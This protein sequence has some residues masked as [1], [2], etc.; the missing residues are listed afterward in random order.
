MSFGRISV[1]KKY[2]ILSAMI[3]LLIF[4]FY[5]MFTLKTQLSPETNAPT[6]TVIT[7]YP[8]ALALDVTTDVSKPLED[9]FGKLNGISDISST[10]QDNMS[11]IKLTFDYSTDLDQAAIDIQNTVS[12]IKNEL[13]SGIEESQVLKFSVS[14][15]PIMTIGLE[16]KNI[17]MAS[18]RELSENNI[19]TRLQLVEGVAAVNIFGGYEQEIQVQLDEAK[20]KSYGL[21]IEQISKTLQ[22]TNIKAP[23]GSIR[24]DGKDLMLRVEESIISTAELESIAIPLSTGGS[25]PLSELGEVNSGIEDLQASYRLNG[26]EGFALLITK[27]SDSNTV[28]VTKNV[29]EELDDLRN[30]Y[31]YVDFLVANDDSIF[32]N[33]MVANMASSVL[34]A[35][36][37]TMIVILLFITEVSRA[38]VISI[39]MPLVFLSTI[40]LMKAFGMNLDLVTLSALILSIGFVVDTS[41]VVVENVNSHFGK[42]KSIYDAAIDGTDEI[43]IPSIAGATTTLIVLFPLLFIEGF[44]GEMFRPLSMTL[45]FAIASSLFV[46]LLM[47]PLLTV[48]LDPFKFKKM[49]RV[50]S[51]FTKPFNRFMDTLLE[52]YLLLS[53][54]V[55]K[56]KKSTLL[57][58]LALLIASGAFIKLNGMEMLPKFDSGVSYITLEMSPG[59]PLDETSLTVS[60]LED[61]LKQQPEVDSF[62]SRIGYEKG[63]IQ[64]GDFGIMGTD[65][66][67]ITVNLFSRKERSKSIWEFQEELRKEIELLPGLNR[68]VVKEKGGTAV[69]GAA[70]P[71]QLMIKGDEPE[72]LYNI[73]DQAKLII[74]DVEGTTN[75]FTSYNNLY[76]QMTIDL[77]QDRL[78][79]LGLTSAS[80]SQQ[81]YGRMEGIDSSS[82]LIESTNTL[83]IN[84]GYKDKDISDIDF[85]MNTPIITPVGVEIPLKEIASVEIENRSNLIER[86]NMNYVVRISGFSEG[87]AF[88]HIVADINNSLQ[89][90]ELPKGY[91]IEFTGE[92]EALTDS[93]GDMI[94]LIGLAIIFVYL[95]L[96][97][98][99]SSFMHPIT[100]MAAIPLILIG[101]APALWLTGKYMSMPVFLGF[102][103]LAG[104]VVNNSILLVDA[105]N[106]LR[107][108]G[109]EMQESIEEAIRSRYKPIMMTALSDIVGMLPLA[110]QLA[111]GSERFSPL[112]IAVVGGMLAA[113]LLTIIVIPLIY[114]ILDRVK[115]RFML[116]YTSKA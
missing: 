22:T 33:Q 89:E 41:I 110:L 11:I 114:V 85:L 79:E 105:I 37:F 48:I 59:T 51:T 14:D 112:A 97:P 38:L 72:V 21:S 76:N 5:S 71:L 74:E 54:W 29:S 111:L 26:E 39:S 84:V 16:S 106:R 108:E 7:V 4:G 102:I 69:T 49:E 24:F 95:V 61:Y 56:H 50:L 27:K 116:Y 91:S 46:A 101:V 47:I 77:S 6:A 92:Q 44:V 42:G 25:I 9:A 86:E 98:Q 63:S 115:E 100:I 13:P 28:D 52:K 15:Q 104:T 19:M 94:F 36:L 10:S 18:L 8:G 40:G 31:E 113:T 23:A 53:R 88:S 66:A 107:K 80:V 17:D 99:F 12:R 96:V 2:I 57:I 35:I 43:A 109:K 3:A 67:M 83:D 103:L 32:T 70:A 1:E 55:L 30:D 87:R 82:I 20:I 78:M 90:I 45:I 68:Y 58:L 62:D 65:Q 75:V 60:L 93:L 34:I 81:L 73:A 64:Q